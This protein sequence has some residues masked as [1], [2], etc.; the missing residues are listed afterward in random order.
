MEALT[1]ESHIHTNEP[2]T[3]V[4]QMTIP[5]L[6]P[7]EKEVLETRLVVDLMCGLG[8]ASE[9]IRRALGRSPHVVLNHDPK[10]I[11]L[12]ELNHADSRHYCEDVRAVSPKEACQGKAVWILWLSPDCRH[13]S[14]AKGAAP[15]S[16][17]VRALANVALDW[18]DDVRPE[19][20]IVENVPEF[21]TWGPIDPN[22]NRPIPEQSGTYFASYVQG[23]RDRGYCVEYRVLCAADY[24]APTSRKRFFL[25]AR[26]DGKQICWPEPTHGVGRSKPWRT[27]AECIDWSV[28]PVSIFGRKRPLAEATCRRIAKGTLRYVLGGNPYLVT[29]PRSD[30]T[31]AACLTK[32]YTGVVGQSLDRPLGTITTIDHHSLLAAHLLGIDHRGSGESPVWDITKPFTTITTENRH[33]LSAAYL[34]QYY[35]S[36]S[37]DQAMGAPLR[38]IVTKARHSMV[39]AEL[40]SDLIGAIRVARF[41]RKYAK[42]VPTTWIRIRGRLRPVVTMS[43]QGKTYLLTDLTMRM[44]LPRELAR[45]QGF[46][47]EFKLEG[48]Q[49]QQIRRIGNSVPPQFAEAL[50]LAQTQ[51]G[52]VSM[53]A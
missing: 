22:T 17:S 13:F 16:K 3:T 24:G 23:M 42:S 35:G 49:E 29:I 2:W 37:Q 43:A 47:D 9:G 27:A 18:I 36:G 14:K 28:S 15:V 26:S 5:G 20:I 31:V 38:T 50:V 33:A 25:I 6:D 40:G 8:G 52:P 11:A 51:S 53:S 46:G 45:A 10:A 32:N 41:L 4:R 39:A 48:T 34:V 30:K 1:A 21:V 12:H 19:I 7:F 44:V